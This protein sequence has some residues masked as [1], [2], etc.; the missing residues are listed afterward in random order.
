MNIAI[1]TDT[2]IPRF[3][4]IITSILNTTGEFKRR[5]HNVKIIAP[6]IRKNQEDIIREYNP[7]L[8]VSL[9]PGVKAM[10]YPDFRIT[11]PATPW[12]IRTLKK[13]KVDIIHFHTPFT[14]GMEA[15]LAAAYL[16][17]P[18]VST[19]HTYFVE[20]EYLKI[21]HL[22]RL[23]GLTRFG[24]GYSNFYHNMCDVTVS[25]SQFTA[26][27]L[28]RNNLKCPI[29]VVSNGIPLREPKKFTE[30][31]K[32]A[33]RKKYGLKK[34]VILF[35]GRISVEKCIDVVM[36]AAKQIFE[37][38]DDTTLLIVGDGPAFDYL[39]KTSVDLGIQDNTVFTGGI[40][41]DDL[42]KSGLFEISRFFITASTSENQ[43]MTIIEASMFGLPLIG[44]NARGVPEMIKG[45]GFIAEPGNSEEIAGYMEKLLEDDDLYKEMSIKA[46]EM[47]SNYDI[48]KTTDKMLD[49]YHVIKKKVKRQGKSRKVSLKTMYKIFRSSYMY[50]RSRY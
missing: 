26:D 37:N 28:E 45:N 39:K 46:K 35:I 1:F 20:P 32:E 49:L 10:F 16:G 48:R 24:W 18:L 6:R 44:V 14:L 23:P 21:V 31:E 33:I 47:G 42:L 43:P 34:N 36:K 4:G 8:N 7:N 3:D 41:H 13:L 9:I 22:H 19:F 30:A 11:L 17:K 29:R 27:E 2:F 40:P 5:G 15:I 12:I 38:R 25:P 50:K